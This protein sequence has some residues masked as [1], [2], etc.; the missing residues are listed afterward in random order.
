MPGIAEHGPLPE[1]LPQDVR[2]DRRGLELDPGESVSD[3]S[4]RM[5]EGMS[6]GLGG[7]GQRLRGHQQRGEV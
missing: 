1:G 4:T 6:N 7:Y 5:T 2:L 3:L